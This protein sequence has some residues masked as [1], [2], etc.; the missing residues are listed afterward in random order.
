MNLS[1][2]FFIDFLSTPIKTIICTDS[3]IIIFDNGFGKMPSHIKKIVEKR[4]VILKGYI[5][6]TN[7]MMY[8]FRN[9]DLILKL[10]KKRSKDK[11]CAKI[12]FGFN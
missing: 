11:S 5:S 3:P 1:S 2:I 10:A 6:K 9:F 7:M 4:C 8:K 12:L